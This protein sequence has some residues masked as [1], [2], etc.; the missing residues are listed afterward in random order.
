MPEVVTEKKRSLGTVPGLEIVTIHEQSRKLPRCVHCGAPVMATARS[1]PLVVLA[2]RSGSAGCSFAETKP[3]LA[4]SPPGPG[5]MVTQFSTVR[6]PGGTAKVA[7]TWLLNSRE[8]GGIVVAPNS[9]GSVVNPVAVLA[10]EKPISNDCGATEKRSSR[11]TS[12]ATNGTCDVFVT[13][14][15]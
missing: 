2:A 7:L 13:L 9:F 3:A 6:P 4:C 15:R 5:L 1:R 12:F 11:I 14:M 10:A 8:P